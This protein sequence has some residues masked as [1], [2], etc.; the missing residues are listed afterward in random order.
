MLYLE[1]TIAIS[2]NVDPAPKPTLFP[3]EFS[4]TDRVALISGANRG[5]GLEMALALIEAGA[6]AVYCI[7]LPKTPGEEWEKTRLYAEKMQGKAG[8]GRLEYLRGNVTDQVRDV[9]CGVLW[10][11]IADNGCHVGSYLE[12]RRNHRKSGR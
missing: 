11:C 10:E 12:N 1:L 3:H 4:L 2:I 7:D 6:R 9:G 5:L 8:E